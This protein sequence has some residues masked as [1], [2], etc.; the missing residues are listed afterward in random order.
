MLK[1]LGA[2][3]DTIGLSANGLYNP[4]YRMFKRLGI[5]TL[6][7]RDNWSLFDMIIISK[8]LLNPPKGYRYHSAK[9]F[10]RPFLLQKE[11]AYAGYP[12]RSHVGNNYLGGYSDHL[13]VYIYLAK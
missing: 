1:S 11:G 8:S 5:G 12:W 13:P 6:G 2:A 3:P 4:Y 9:V 10:N 7:F